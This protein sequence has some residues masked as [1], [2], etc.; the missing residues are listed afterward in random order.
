MTIAKVMGVTSYSA[1][2]NVADSDIA[3]VMGVTQGGGTTFEVRVDS[4]GFEAVGLTYVGGNNGYV[5][6][7]SGFVINSS[8]LFTS[9]DVAQ[10]TTITSATITLY[11]QID[12]SGVGRWYAWNDDNAPACTGDPGQLPSDVPKTTAFTTFI[13][14]D[15]TGVHDVTT[16][17]QEILNRGGFVSGNNINLLAMDNGSGTGVF[18]EWQWF[19]ADETEEALLTIVY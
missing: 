14:G 4:A 8:G 19:G 11:N 13:N 15:G 18:D 1:V 3:N 10:G 2:M 7:N 17:V 5:G 12:G 9:V 16:V 6:D